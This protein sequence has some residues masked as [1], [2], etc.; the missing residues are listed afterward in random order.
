MWS[1]HVRETHRTPYDRYVGMVRD[2]LPFV[3]KRRRPQRNLWA[4]GGA[5]ALL[6]ALTAFGVIKW[7]H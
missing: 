7:R 5:L 2:R 4:I 6:V 3:K 1:W